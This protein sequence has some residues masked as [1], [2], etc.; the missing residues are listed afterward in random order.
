MLAETGPCLRWLK[1]AGVD[2]GGS[3]GGILQETL[4]GLA[5]RGAGRPRDRP[6]GTTE[7]AGTEP[8]RPRHPFRPL[9]RPTPTL[10]PTAPRRLRRHAPQP[11]SGPS[12]RRKPR[13]PNPTQPQSPDRTGTSPEPDYRTWA[14]SSS[15]RPR[16]PCHQPGPA[17]SRSSPPT[18]TPSHP[19]R[20]PRRQGTLQPTR[21]GVVS[22]TD[23]GA[24]VHVTGPVTSA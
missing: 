2:D 1:G 18:Q 16:T 21:S 8:P 5:C 19:T 13:N 15:H 4:M 9:L 24:D 12:P 6:G 14:A 10:P 22:A 23:L 11:T 17:R 3:R 7:T 20:P